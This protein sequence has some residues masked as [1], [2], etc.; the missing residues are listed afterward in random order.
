M[1]GK[2]KLP[3][4]PPPILTEHEIIQ[5]MARRLRTSEQWFR[6]RYLEEYQ[7]K[8]MQRATEIRTP[9]GNRG[10]LVAAASVKKQDEGL[11]PAADPAGKE[12]PPPRGAGGCGDHS[13]GVGP[14]ASVALSP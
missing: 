7:E 4:T 12:K 14:F 8:A 1:N 3:L 13:Y 11:D 2:R 10:R 6:R 9:Q 5:S